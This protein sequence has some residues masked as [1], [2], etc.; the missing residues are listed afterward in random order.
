MGTKIAKQTANEVPPQ[1]F[2]HGQV[3]LRQ[4]N[5][6][7]APSNIRQC[8][9][10]N[11]KAAS[12]QFKSISSSKSSLS[13]HSKESVESMVDKSCDKEESSPFHQNPSIYTTLKSQNS[14][15]SHLPKRCL[16][17]G[18]G[19]KGVGK[20]VSFDISED[21]I[22]PTSD[23]IDEDNYMHLT[24]VANGNP[25]EPLEQNLGG[26]RPEG[27]KTSKKKGII[28]KEQGNDELLKKLYSEHIDV[29]YTNQANLEHT[30]MVQQKLF[31]QQLH[32][33]HKNLKDASR[34]ERKN[35]PF[36]ISSREAPLAS[37]EAG[38]TD[39]N[40]ASEMQWVVKRRSDGSR[41]V[42]EV[43]EIILRIAM[44]ANAQFLWINFIFEGSQ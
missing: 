40:S 19:S 1:D 17:S 29:M 11:E 28:G 26:N 27:V 25:V 43:I 22:L 38:S 44:N 23:N 37:E 33:L 30:M 5:L 21:R 4:S 32:L 16:R 42:G 39:R 7:L 24:N 34:G 20:N 3:W 2:E 36:Q 6:N 12:E 9:P 14:R 41:F 15:T 35:P 31:T 18:T 13:D 10:A 8:N